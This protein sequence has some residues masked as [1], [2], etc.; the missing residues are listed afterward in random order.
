M[1][2]DVFPQTRQVEGQKHF[3]MKYKPK[4]LGECCICEEDV[5]KLEYFLRNERYFCVRSQSGCGSTTCAEEVAKKLSF[6]VH[7]VTCSVGCTE[8]VKLMRQNMKNVLLEMQKQNKKVLFFIKDIEIMKRNE[9]AQVTSCIEESNV[10]AILFYNDNSFFTK[11]KIVTLKEPTFYDKMV[12]LHWIVAEE[13]LD[14]EM[15]ELENIANLR[16]FRY[17]IN[18]LMIKNTNILTVQER[19]YSTVDDFSKILFVNETLKFDTID[20][21]CFFTDLFCTID[22]AD[23]KPSKYWFMD[24]LS[25]YIDNNRIIFTNKQSLIARN[26]QLVHRTSCLRRSANLIGVDI[27]NMS[28]YTSLLRKHVL[29][30]ETVYS[31]SLPDYFTRAKA[32]YTIAKINASAIQCKTMKVM[33]KI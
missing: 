32:M 11:W 14:V 20:E 27:V 3:S 2:D 22:I 9:R 30:G 5:K 28:Y 21:T 6:F 16:D 29:D 24:L 4:N 12:H 26:A 8:V 31:S 19:D 1:F 15:D 33:L 17:G 7:Y 25:E 10:N 18:S 13:K 23:F